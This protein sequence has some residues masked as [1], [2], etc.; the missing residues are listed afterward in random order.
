[1]FVRNGVMTSGPSRKCDIT[2]FAK[3]RPKSAQQLRDSTGG[4]AQGAERNRL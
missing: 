2:F 4:G 1:M 3:G